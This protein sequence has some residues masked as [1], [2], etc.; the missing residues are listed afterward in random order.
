MIKKRFPVRFTT[1]FDHLHLWRYGDIHFVMLVTDGGIHSV[2][3]VNYEE[4]HCVITYG[5]I[6]HVITN[7]VWRNSPCNHYIVFLAGLGM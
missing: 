7:T 4:I 2:V 6:T 3:T 1:L 5:E